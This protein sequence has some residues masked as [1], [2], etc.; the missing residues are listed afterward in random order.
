M[1]FIELDLM[2]FEVSNLVVL[3]SSDSLYT[4]FAGAKCSLQYQGSSKTT[5]LH[6]S[7]ESAQQIFDTFD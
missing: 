4:Y 6:P 3:G 5:V 1:N 2:D 7:L